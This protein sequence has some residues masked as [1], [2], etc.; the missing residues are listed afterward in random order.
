MGLRMGQST[1]GSAYEFANGSGSVCE[2]VG[3]RLYIEAPW[4]GGMRLIRI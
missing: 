3:R 4:D 1:N 2:W